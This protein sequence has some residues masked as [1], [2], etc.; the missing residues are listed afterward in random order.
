MLERNLIH[1]Q[2]VAKPLLATQALFNISEFILQRN[3]IYVKNVT[4]PFVI[5]H[6]LLDISEFTLEKNLI[7]VQMWQSLYRSNLIQHQRIHAR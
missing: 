4:K 1:V 5:R 6:F 7:N 3:L 2:H